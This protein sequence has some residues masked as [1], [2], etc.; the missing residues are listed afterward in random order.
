MQDDGK[1]KQIKAVL[2]KIRKEHGAGTIM[3]LDN[4]KWIFP[5]P[6]R[7]TFEW[8]LKTS[9]CT[10]HFWARHTKEWRQIFHRQGLQ[11]R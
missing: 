8:F 10:V 3:R 7:K 4:A 11:E 6:G 2:D 1:K 5:G 9:S